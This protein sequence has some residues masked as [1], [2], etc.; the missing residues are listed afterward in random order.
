MT[1]LPTGDYTSTVTNQNSLDG[2]MAVGG[3]NTAPTVTYL[4][5][6]ATGVSW[7]TNTAE[8]RFTYSGWNF[9]GTYANS[10]FSGTADNGQSI[11]GEID[12]WE[13]DSSKEE[14]AAA[15]SG[16]E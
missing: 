6:T 10:G 16:R 15:G 7:D 3:T 2:I 12:E 11:E 9:K 13:A 14:T 4:G 5:V 1:N 8:L